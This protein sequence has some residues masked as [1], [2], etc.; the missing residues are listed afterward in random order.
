MLKPNTVP[1][2]A[3]SAPRE[4]SH[5]VRR[6]NLL[7]WSSG[8]LL[9]KH[10]RLHDAIAG[11][12]PAVAFTLCFYA[13]RYTT[14][15]IANFG[16]RPDWIFLLALASLIG[17][18]A[19]SSVRYRHFPRIF[20]LLLRST[21]VGVLVYLV[22]EPPDFTL[23]NDNAA[24]LSTYVEWGYWIA[25]GSAVASVWRPSLIFPAAL[26]AMSTRYVVETIS[27]Y[28]IS[29][30]DI[31]YMI[32]MAQ[33]LACAACALSLLS[34]AQTTS[35]GRVNSVLLLIDRDRL[36]I[37]LAFIAFGFHLGNYFWSGYQKLAIGPYLWS[38]AIEN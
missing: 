20:S 37:C 26:Y 32:E 33:F 13:F 14:V 17:A 27:G 31:V 24:I 5:F 21:V 7:S 29:T 25:L 28:S 1:S 22:V 18:V 15:A 19:F 35:M 23:V 11:K 2:A 34:W 16:G 12:I 38:W 36:A 30:L 9:T 4:L 8:P 3:A 10:V 6:A